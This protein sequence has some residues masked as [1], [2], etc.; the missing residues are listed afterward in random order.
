MKSVSGAAR[1]Q[2]VL[3]YG[4]FESRA[5][6]RIE[7]ELY[8]LIYHAL[9]TVPNTIFQIAPAII[10]HKVHVGLGSSATYIYSKNLYKMC[11][12]VHIVYS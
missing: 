11:I 9:C 3:Q 2:R 1:R 10:K 12:T 7:Q 4:R 6:G 5:R 8:A